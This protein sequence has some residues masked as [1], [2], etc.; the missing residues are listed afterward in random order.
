MLKRTL[1]FPVEDTETHSRK[2]ILPRLLGVNTKRSHCDY[3]VL[4]IA[5]LC[6]YYYSVY[7]TGKHRA[8]IEWTAKA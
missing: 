8:L 5:L 6:E 2:G 7:F 3:T 4:V 1:E